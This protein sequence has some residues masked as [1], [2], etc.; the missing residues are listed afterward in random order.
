MTDLM[1]TPVPPDQSS[2]LE[3]VYLFD[4]PSKT[5]I[6]A[7]GSPFDEATFEVISDYITFLVR[8][9]GLYSNIKQQQNQHHQTEGSS[10]ERYSTSTLRLAPD[11]TLCF[12]QICGNLALVYVVRNDLQAKNAGMIVS[13]QL[14][15]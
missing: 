15:G 4:V 2:K 6:S 11:T 9:S 7:D 1:H 3:K 8:F 12:H 10:A 14:G 13:M 5:Y